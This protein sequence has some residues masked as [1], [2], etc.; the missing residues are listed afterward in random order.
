MK[1]QKI[2]FNLNFNGVQCQPKF[3]IVKKYIYLFKGIIYKER[4]KQAN[5]AFSLYRNIYHLI[6]LTEPGLGSLMPSINTCFNVLIEG[7]PRKMHCLK[8]YLS[9]SQ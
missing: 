9:F 6:L 1:N 2:H 5:T 3:N 4:K 7:I 8:P